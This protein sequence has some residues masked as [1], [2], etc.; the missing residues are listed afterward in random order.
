MVEYIPHQRCPASA[1][2]S[3]LFFQILN[4]KVAKCA[5]VFHEKFTKVFRAKFA[6][7]FT[8]SSQSRKGLAQ[9]SQRLF[10][11]IAKVFRAKFAKVFTQSSQSS[12]RFFTKSSQRIS[13]SLSFDT[14]LRPTTLKASSH[15]H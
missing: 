12:Q 15:S 1:F 2:I 7:V 11:K 14:V 6:K 4:R 3:V 10:A 8:Q 13:I 9:S 5:K